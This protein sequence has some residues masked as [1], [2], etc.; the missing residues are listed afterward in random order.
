MLMNLKS[1]ALI[2]TKQK[3]SSFSP[4]VSQKSIF[5]GLTSPVMQWCLLHCYV[6]ILAFCTAGTL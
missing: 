6:T 2:K 5:A 4:L 1:A 3:K